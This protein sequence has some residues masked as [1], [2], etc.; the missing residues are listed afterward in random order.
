MRIVINVFLCSAIGSILGFSGL[1]ADTWQYW[2]VT[3][4]I[5]G[6]AI[7]AALW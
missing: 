3:A 7:N 5:I 6:V 4:C 2:A 1:G